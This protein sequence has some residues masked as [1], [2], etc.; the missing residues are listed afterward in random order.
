MSAEYSHP[1]PSSPVGARFDR[2]SIVQLGCQEISLFEAM[3]AQVV[4]VDGGEGSEC[5]S[6]L[7]VMRVR[8][9]LEIV[10]AENAEELWR[11]CVLFI[12]TQFSNLYPAKLSGFDC[13]QPHF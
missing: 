10:I 3:T 5:G 11:E 2:A 1:L 9:R 12:G 7:D 8:A 6:C 4:P 13:H